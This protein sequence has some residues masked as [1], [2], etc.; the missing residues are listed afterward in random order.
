MIVDILGLMEALVA[1]FFYFI[2]PICFIVQ[3]PKLKAVFRS[4]D[5]SSGA[6]IERQKNEVNNKANLQTLELTASETVV[7]T[8]G[9]QPLVISTEIQGIHNSGSND[10]KK[11]SSDVHAAGDM[12]VSDVVEDARING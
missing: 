9:L 12:L 2:V 8:Q 7:S 5:S 4:M 10:A 1:P 3:Y 6:R 11:D